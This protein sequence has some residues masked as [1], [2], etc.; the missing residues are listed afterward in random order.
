MGG[1]ILIL[2]LRSK[3]TASQPNLKPATLQSPTTPAKKKISDIAMEHFNRAIDMWNNA[4]ESKLDD[5]LRRDVCAELALAI[6]KAGAPFPRAHA[7]LA[8]FF[9]DLGDDVS[10]GHHANK[11]LQQNPNEFRAQF[12]R[13]DVVLKN[14]RIA[15]VKTGEVIEWS[16][17]I[18]NMIFGTLGKAI[19]AGVISSQAGRTQTDFKNEVIKLVKIFRNVNRTNTD[20]E[21]F[22]MM[23]NLLIGVGDFIK[24]L[25]MPG[26]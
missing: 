20:I 10:A 14:V 11:A 22:V 15:K 12:V 13:I 2:I 3:N 26:G 6:N 18:E 7:L 17:N 8:M 9:N 4:D 21:E 23:A 16:G 24:D 1:F 19:A 25:P 5:N